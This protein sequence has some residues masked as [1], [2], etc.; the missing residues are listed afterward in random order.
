M[1]APWEWL[2]QLARED[3]KLA[4]AAELLRGAYVGQNK[5]NEQSVAHFIRGLHHQHWMLVITVPHLEDGQPPLGF[6]WM[7]VKRSAPRAAQLLEAFMTRDP[8]QVWEY[9][10]FCSGYP[11]PS[12]RLL[13]SVFDEQQLLELNRVLE[14]AIDHLM[15]MVL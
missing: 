8:E 1:T 2:R 15:L 13:Q 3:M 9:A 7:H 12:Y 6:E 11:K 14:D 4:L 5:D 10:Q